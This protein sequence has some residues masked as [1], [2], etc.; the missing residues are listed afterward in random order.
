LADDGQGFGLCTK[1]LS[2]RRF[3]WWPP[4]SP[5]SVTLSAWELPVL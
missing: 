4:A 3:P 2:H 1:R 5:Q